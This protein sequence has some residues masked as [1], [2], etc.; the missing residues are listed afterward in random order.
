MSLDAVLSEI[1]S[2]N[3][4]IEEP[5]G[6]PLAH[7]PRPVLIASKTAKICICGQ[8][9]GIRVH[10]SGI[11]FSDPSGNRLRD[12]LGLSSEEFYDSKQI[13]IIP[14]GFCFP[15]YNEKGADLP[16]RIECARIWRESLFQHL[17][18]IELFVLVGFYAQRWHLGQGCKRNLTETVKAWNEYNVPEMSP[19][20]I[21][22]PHPSWRNNAW[23]RKNRWFEEEIIPFLRKKVRKLLCF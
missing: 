1:K 12:W 20:Y 9:P 7:A 2:C 4:C 10:N 13:S 23:L 21:P 19:N 5:A 18:Q 17:K 14:M 3:Y 11:P 16:P 8:A 15:G 22:L 6:K